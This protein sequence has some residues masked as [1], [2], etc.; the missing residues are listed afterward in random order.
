MLADL[1]L[2]FDSLKQRAGSENWDTNGLTL[3]AAVFGIA[4]IP[5]VVFPHAR[6]LYPAPASSGSTCG[7]SSCGGG[8][9]CGGGCGGCG[10]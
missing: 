5:T 4:A 1:R 3:F 9:G 2:L 7:S 6:T 10:S 8:G